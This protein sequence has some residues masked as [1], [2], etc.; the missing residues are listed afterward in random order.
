MMINIIIW[1][2]ISHYLIIMTKIFNIITIHII[3]IVCCCQFRCSGTSKPFSNRKETSCLMQDSSCLGHL[4]ASRPNARWQ[5]NQLS[6]RDS[7]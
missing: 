1:Y 3:I 5:T 6:Y 4:I 7:S 2:Q